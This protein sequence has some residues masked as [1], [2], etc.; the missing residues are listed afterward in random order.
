MVFNPKRYLS[1]NDFEIAQDLWFLRQQDVKFWISNP[2]FR[3]EFKRLCENHSQG[4]LYTFYLAADN[5][6]KK[7]LRGDS[8][9]ETDFDFGFAAKSLDRIQSSLRIHDDRNFDRRLAFMYK[10]ISLHKYD[11]DYILMNEDLVSRFLTSISFGEEVDNA[12]VL[13]VLQDVLS[14]YVA[15]SDERAY[16]LRKITGNLRRKMGLPPLPPLKDLRS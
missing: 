16:K 6:Y 3:A 1:M 4:K 8:G 14:R 7:K 11:L 13:T 15:Q 10:K 2:D 9:T 5:S 12:S